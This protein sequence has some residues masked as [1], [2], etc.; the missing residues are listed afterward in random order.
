MLCKY[1]RKNVEIKLLFGLF[2]SLNGFNYDY[3]LSY[4][5]IEY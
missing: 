5:T 4:D 1:S 3:G 2:C